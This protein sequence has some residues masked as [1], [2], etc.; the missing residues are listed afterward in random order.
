MEALFGERGDGSRRE[1][2]FGDDRHERLRPILRNP[3]AHARAAMK[4]VRTAAAQHVAF[5]SVLF[6]CVRTFDPQHLFRKFKRNICR[7][8][9]TA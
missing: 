7:L 5:G 8:R 6:D 4:P 3:N 2:S 1:L 9:D